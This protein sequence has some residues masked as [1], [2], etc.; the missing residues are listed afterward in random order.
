MAKLESKLRGYIADIAIQHMNWNSADHD[1]RE[2]IPAR[3]RNYVTLVSETN[4]SR[5]HNYLRSDI[6]RKI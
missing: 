5:L 1:K 6:T 3:F 2:R 4:E